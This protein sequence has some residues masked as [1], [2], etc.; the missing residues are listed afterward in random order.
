VRNALTNVS[1]DRPKGSLYGKQGAYTLRTDD[2][3]RSPDVWNNQIIAYRNGGPIRVRDVGKAIVGPQN[4]DPTG[5]SRGDV[6]IE[7]WNDHERNG[8]GC[9]EQGSGSHARLLDYQDHRDDDW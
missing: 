6:A 2:Q 9:I 8:E 1:V 4:V 3:L 5:H 7:K